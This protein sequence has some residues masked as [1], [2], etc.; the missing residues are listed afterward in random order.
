MQKLDRSNLIY[1]KYYMLLSYQKKNSLLQKQRVY[2]FFIYS[3][4]NPNKQWDDG[5][6]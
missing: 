4:E 1:R 5:K 2:A 6:I 3:K